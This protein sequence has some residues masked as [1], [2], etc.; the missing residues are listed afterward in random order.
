MRISAG[1]PPKDGFSNKG[2]R[3]GVDR[4]LNT[5]FHVREDWHA[6]KTAVIDR[7]A[8]LVDANQAKETSFGET[9]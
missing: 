2:C 1:R 7:V 8:E 9:A 6:G 3:Y 4:G 5:L